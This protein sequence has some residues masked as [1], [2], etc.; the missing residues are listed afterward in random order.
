MV[1]HQLRAVA[2]VERRVDEVFAYAAATTARAITAGATRSLG[3]RLMSSPS[4]R[5]ARLTLAPQLGAETCQ[6]AAPIVTHASAPQRDVSDS[7]VNRSGLDST[8]D[9]LVRRVV[10]D[11]TRRA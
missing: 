1:C 5:F 3:I 9:H 8:V 11:A 7:G 6:A 4:S 10:S 2:P